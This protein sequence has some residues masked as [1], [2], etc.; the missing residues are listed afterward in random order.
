MAF[1][2]HVPA[3]RCQKVAHSLTESTTSSC[4]WSRLRRNGLMLAVLWLF[5][6]ACLV[7]QQDERAVRA[8]YVFNLTKYVTWPK[9]KNR[10]TIC[11]TGAGSMGPV[12]KQVL[13]D[14]LVDGRKIVV[15][16]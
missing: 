12:L 9:P 14:K 13:E 15:L 3:E 2:D 11:A 7:A 16:V 8:A 5:S 10:L 4:M 1:P 6:S